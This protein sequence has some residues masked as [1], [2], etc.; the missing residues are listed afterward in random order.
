M[1]ISSTHGTAY[2]TKVRGN[3]WCLES[4]VVDEDHRNEGVGSK[5]M[6]RALSK[7]NRPIYLLATSELGGDVKRLIKFYESFGFEKTKQSQKDGLEFNYNMV[8]W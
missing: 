5:L 2:L 6:K 3:G 4:V 1:K 8:L 7:C